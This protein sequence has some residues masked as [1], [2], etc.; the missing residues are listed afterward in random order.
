MAMRCRIAGSIKMLEKR[1]GSDTR[2]RITL[3]RAKM[4]ARESKA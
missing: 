4:V 3:T 2:R 1:C